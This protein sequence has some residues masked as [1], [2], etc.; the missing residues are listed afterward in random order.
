MT[1]PKRSDE[2][3]K[4]AASHVMYEWRMLQKISLLLS[5]GALTG[6]ALHDAAMES[7][8]VHVRCLREFFDPNRTPKPDDV[9]PCDFLNEQSWTPPAVSVRL[10]AAKTDADKRLAHITYA[11]TEAPVSWDHAALVVELGVIFQ[12]FRSVLSN[13]VRAFFE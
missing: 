11:R 7:V 9:M 10:N 1:R 12:S 2:E 13:E 8:V 3:L 6:S 4:K 5:S